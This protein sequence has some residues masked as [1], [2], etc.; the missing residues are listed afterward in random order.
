MHLTTIFALLACVSASRFLKLGAKEC[1]SDKVH[2]NLYE[3]MIY[4]GTPSDISAALHKN[5]SCV[6][7]ATL[8][9]KIHEESRDWRDADNFSRVAETLAALAESS[10]VSTVLKRARGF[11]RAYEYILK[12]ARA[13]NPRD[14]S[15][16]LLES[17]DADNLMYG[18]LVLQKPQ[19]YPFR[20][21][22]VI[23][24]LLT[25]LDPQDQLSDTCREDLEDVGNWT[26]LL[27]EFDGSNTSWVKRCVS[28]PTLRDVMHDAVTAF[29]RASQL[30]L[31][32]ASRTLHFAEKNLSGQNQE[33]TDIL[34]RAKD[35]VAAVTNTLLQAVVDADTDDPSASHPKCGSFYWFTARISKG[36]NGPINRH[37]IMRPFTV[38]TLLT[39]VGAS[40]VFKRMVSRKT[41]CD[42]DRVHSELL[43][44]LAA[45]IASTEIE[46]TM[47]KHTCVSMASLV[48]VMSE[49]W[50]FSDNDSNRKA[51]EV[52]RQMYRILQRA[53]D[54]KAAFEYI[55]RISHAGNPYDFST[56]LVDSIEAGSPMYWHKSGES[57]AYK[58]PKGYDY[59]PRVAVDLL[60]L[61]DPQEQLSTYCREG[62]KQT[63]NWEQLLTHFKHLNSGWLGECVEDQELRKG[64]R[65]V[66]TTFEQTSRLNLRAATRITPS[67]DRSKVRYLA[68]SPR[69]FILN[70]LEKVSNYRDKLANKVFYAM[71]DANSADP[72]VVFRHVNDQFQIYP[73]EGNN[74]EPVQPIIEPLGNCW[75]C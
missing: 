24:D 15:A 41:L 16:E 54:Y 29:E 13:T 65:N 57:P 30:R 51:M 31:H 58:P 14:F 33:H 34:Q 68:H 50:A 21:P 4:G 66:A 53:G 72:E 12:V 56:E 44:Q 1:D 36:L 61:I 64:I 55:L 69:P 22:M 43:E 6:T 42:P 39:Y 49:Q 59:G 45:G 10:S 75:D 32:T 17:L 70:M 47:S 19:G 63:M 38:I 52:K 60:A 35:Y 3:K 26:W 27:K 5:K 74:F 25:I 67:E 40:R 71:A 28:D 20:Q 23:N 18:P 73:A 37:N 7:L 9:N 46:R 48:G 8:I 62:L 2:Q 11:K